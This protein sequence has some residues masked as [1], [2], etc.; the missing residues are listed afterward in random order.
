MV[1]FMFY[2]TPIKFFL[3]LIQKIFKKEP[4]AMYGSYLDS[5]PYTWT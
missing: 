3:I 1:K 5:V 2:F 4:T